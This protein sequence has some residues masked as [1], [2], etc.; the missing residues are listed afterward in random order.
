MIPRSALAP[1]VPL[2]ASAKFSSQAPLKDISV[3]LGKHFQAEIECMPFAC[4][5]VAAPELILPA[6]ER[7]MVIRK[8][9]GSRKLRGEACRTTSVQMHQPLP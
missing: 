8:A 4:G 2:L 7:M 1:D 3:A 9:E 6:W 5:L